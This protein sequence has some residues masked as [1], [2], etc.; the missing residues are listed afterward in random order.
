[1][2][3]SVHASATLTCAVH[4]RRRA[5]LSGS[6]RCQRFHVGCGYVSEAHLDDVLRVV[7][8]DARPVGEL[9]VSEALGHRLEA[10]I[11]D[12]DGHGGL[13]QPPEAVAA[14]CQVTAVGET[15]PLIAI[16]FSGAAQCSQAHSP[17]LPM[18]PA[19]HASGCCF[20]A[21]ALRK[22]VCT[23]VTTGWFPGCAVTVP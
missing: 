7:Q 2:R 18:A 3:S 16:P 12:H 10:V 1:M 14:P 9:H 21:P 4:H 20:G 11:L 17:S 6:Q 23:P 8:L 5:T 19:G 15:A 22:R 13:R